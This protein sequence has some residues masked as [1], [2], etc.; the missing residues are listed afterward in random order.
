MNKFLFPHQSNIE[1][2]SQ[3]ITDKTVSKSEA[4]YGNWE[5]T[6]KIFNCAETLVNNG[7]F[8][9]VTSSIEQETDHW[10]RSIRQSQTPNGKIVEVGCGGGRILAKLI[11]NDISCH[12]LD[13][14]PLMLERC[15]E[16]GFQAEEADVYKP[17]KPILRENFDFA[18]VSVNTIFNTRGKNRDTWIKYCSDLV[19]PGGLIMFTAYTYTKDSS[20]KHAERFNYYQACT[21]PFLSPN[22]TLSFWEEKDGR[23]GVHTVDKNNKET[24]FTEWNPKNLILKQL[25]DWQKKFNL[26]LVDMELLP[27]EIAYHVVLKKQA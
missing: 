16:R 26:E 17:L 3:Q 2:H 1:I 10:I 7:S 9:I 8:P 21:E 25:R 15:H 13:N 23:A 22:E 12:G 18:G 11:H 4:F 19:K 24:W 14:N 20:K 6:L 5:Q 27:C